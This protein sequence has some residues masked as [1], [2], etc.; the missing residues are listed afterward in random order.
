MWLACDQEEALQLYSLPNQDS[1]WLKGHTPIIGLDL[2]EHSY[3]L[4]YQNRRVEYVEAWWQV[5]RLL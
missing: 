2:W 4:Q 5:L 1:P 3:Y